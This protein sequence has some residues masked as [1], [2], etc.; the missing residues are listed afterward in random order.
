MNDTS[1]YLFLGTLTFWLGIAGVLFWAV[2]RLGRAE[3]RLDEAE[4]RISSG[5]RSR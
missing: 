1:G 2:R 3:R 5:S 4:R